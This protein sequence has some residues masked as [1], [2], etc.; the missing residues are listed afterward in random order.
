MAKLTA[1][2]LYSATDPAAIPFDSTADAAP[3]TGLVGQERALEAIEFAIGMRRDG[4]NLFVLGPAGTGKH[5]LIQHLL[6]TQAAADPVPPDWAYVHNFENP[7]QPRA[8][9]LPPGRAAPL[10]A[11]MRR[12][13]QELRATLPAAFESDDYR[14][15]RE[16]V[17][18]QFKQ[19]QERA[20][21][22]LSERAQKEDVALVR[23][24]NGLALAP[25]RDGEVMAPDVFKALPQPDQD[26]LKAAIERF[27]EELQAIVRRLPDWEREHRELVRQLNRDVT[28]F[29]VAHL[30]EEMRKGF[31]D[32]TAVQ[33]FLDAVE[34]DIMDHAEDFLPKPQQGPEAMMGVLAGGAGGEPASGRRYQVNVFVDQT[35]ATGAPVVYEDHPTHPT[36]VGRIEHQ[37]RFGALV[38]DFNLMKPGALHAA[39]GGY[40]VLDAY[41]VLANGFAWESLKRALAARR[42][43][44]ESLEAMLSMT[45]TV[46]LEPEPIPLDIKVVLIGPPQLYYMLAANDPDFGKLFKV[47]ADFDDRMARDGGNTGLYARLIAASAV[48]AGIRPVDR[49]GMARLIDHSARMTGDSERLSLRVRIL[50]DLMQ[51]ADWQAGR[52]G[53]PTVDAAAVQRAIDAQRR[54]DDRLYSRALEEMRRGTYLVETTGTAVGQINGLA[55]QSI[56]GFS[57]GLP[58]RITARVRLG[59]GEVRDIERESELGGSLHTKGVLI[60]TGFLGSRFGLNR[61]LA[62]AATLVFEQSYGGV[63]GDS[64][65]STELYAL[66]S[67][68]SEIPLKQSI[69]VTGSVDQR[70]RVQ[71]IGGV[72][73]KV[74]GFFDV[75]AARGLTGEQGVMIPSTNVKNLM[76]RPDVARAVAEGR[77]HVWSVA[78]VDEGIEIL[79]GVPAGEADAGGNWPPGTVNHAVARRLARF[80]DRAEAARPPAR[81]P[82]SVGREHRHGRRDG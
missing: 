34:R 55:V 52:A 67:A 41:R 57:F 20:F 72:N 5:T 36:L 15:R 24:P 76:V 43:K 10:A 3:L 12:L 23:T 49:T 17:D 61:R 32:L 21:V 73:E 56:G 78:T 71:P 18:E 65:S 80:A 9:R 19:R 79:T 45:S 44:L 46:L 81:G 7:S 51:E 2:Q 59:N 31:L 60:L 14:Q 54:R 37:A 11:A 42:V 26:R 70:G 38:T 28:R 30:I 64:A 74:E 62:L 33:A 69:A 16:V 25:A 13:V 63:D 47:G 75:C 35:G 50:E 39:N 82:G 77:F 22:D 58:S 66:L 29:A 40:L 4:Y 68:L 48:R 27:Q 8:L 53:S 1:D 6:T